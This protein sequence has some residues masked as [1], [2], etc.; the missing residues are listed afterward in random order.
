[1]RSLLVAVVFC[2]LAH[3]QTFKSTVDQVAVPVTIQSELNES[4]IDLQPDDFLVFEDGRPVPIAA[5]GRIRQSVHILLLL[6][7]VA[8]FS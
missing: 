7:T 6:E 5:F 4:V 1:M 8:P 2:G 3:A